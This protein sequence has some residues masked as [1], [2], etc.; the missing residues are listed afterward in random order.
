MKQ[1]QDLVNNVNDIDIAII[2]NAYLKEKNK[3]MCLLYASWMYKH[4]NEILSNHH[5]AT[6]YVNGTISNIDRVHFENFIRKM[7]KYSLESPVRHKDVLLVYEKIYAF[8]ETFNAFNVADDNT[9]V[10]VLSYLYGIC[11][12]YSWYVF[13]WI[14]T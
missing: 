1:D 13:H 3:E 9:S 10:N 7:L 14:F 5:L 12:Y 6:Q 2:E 11:S 8:L 4:I